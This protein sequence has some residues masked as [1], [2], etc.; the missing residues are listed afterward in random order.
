[1]ADRPDP[2]V[3]RSLTSEVKQGRDSQQR[4][5]LKTFG[6]WW[7]SMLQPRGF[8]VTDLC[9]QIRDGVLPFRLLEAL[10]LLPAAPVIDGKI[11]TFGQR[12]EAKPKLR[13]QR[14]ENLAAFVKVL[15]GS[16]GVKLVNIGAEDLEEGTMALVL[17]LTWA[18]IKRYELADIA[19]GLEELADSAA[20]LHWV[21]EPG[22][23]SAG[24]ST[25]SSP[26]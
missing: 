15:S 1:M 2:A 17:G 10:E 24:P 19:R 9:Q 16:K 18:L 14:L 3:R 11:T 5:Q 12:I 4:G 6:R 26:N 25:A 20:L 8:P 13:V 23:H 22:L 7:N 21:R